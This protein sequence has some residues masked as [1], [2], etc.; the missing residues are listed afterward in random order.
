MGKQYCQSCCRLYYYFTRCGFHFQGGSVVCVT[1]GS[2]QP[3]LSGWPGAGRSEESP[4]PRKTL[5]RNH[6]LLSAHICLTRTWSH[7]H[8]YLLELMCMLVLTLAE[9][10]RINQRTSWEC[11]KCLLAR[12]WRLICTKTQLLA[13]W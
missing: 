1:S 12:D 6:I 5:S 13:N 8:L 4:F 11:Y 3:L 7:A 10:F 2:H 9:G